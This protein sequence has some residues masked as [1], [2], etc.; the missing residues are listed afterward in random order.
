MIRFT[1]VDDTGTI[2]FAGPG[3]GLKALAAAC[4]TGAR[5]HRSLLEALATYDAQL[6]KFVLD[7]LAVFDEHVSLTNP[8]S[9]AAWLSQPHD[10]STKPFR[11]LDDWTRR[12]SL[13]PRRLGVVIFNL[14]A[15]R[16][17]QVQNSY[18]ELLRTDRGRIRVDGRPTTC[19]YCYSLPDEWS[20]LP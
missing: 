17:V 2:S 11:V 14:S 4:T 1:I 6:S 19:F 5:D 7:G 8:A 3:H 18:G 15:R 20:I 16:I 10:L 12:A 9:I 13:E